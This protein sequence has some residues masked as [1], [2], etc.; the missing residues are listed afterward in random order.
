MAKTYKDP[1]TLDGLYKFQ[2]GV[3]KTKILAAKKLVEEAL[4]GSSIAEG[5]LK[6]AMTTSD[7]P[8]NI[9]QLTNINFYEQF[10]VAPRTW[11][12]IAGTRVSTSLERVKL[13]SLVRE[14]EDGVLGDGDPKHVAPVVPEGSAYPFAQLKGIESRGAGI[15]KRGFKVDFTFEAFQEDPVGFIQALPG[16]MNEVALDSE[17]YEVY[18]ALLSGVGTSQQLAGGKIAET[19]ERVVANSVLTRAALIQG[20]RELKQRKFNGRFINITG[21]INLIVPVGQGDYANF[22]INNYSLAEQ[23]VTNSSTTN[24][25]SIGAGYN[26]LGVLNVIESEYITGTQWFLVPA[27]GSVSRPVLEHLTWTGQRAPEL[28]ISNF[29]GTYVGGGAVSPWE[30]SFANDSATFRLRQFG[31]GALWTPDAVLWSLGTGGA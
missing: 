27:P 31:G 6:E 22:L 4:N 13:Y 15:L 10:D 9:A 30:G 19:G 14:W 1:F 2:P 7:L 12:S 5:T 26:P 16:E 24:V 29:T 25:F 8:F 17:E 18:N 11:R 23:R 21:A 20:I 28:R 3:S